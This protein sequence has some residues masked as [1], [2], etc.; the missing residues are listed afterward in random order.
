MEWRATPFPRASSQPRNRT[1]VS[2]ITGR[3]FIIWAT[4]EAPWVIARNMVKVK[5]VWES[6]TQ[7]SLQQRSCWEDHCEPT[8]SAATPLW[9][10]LVLAHAKSMMLPS[11]SQP[12]AKN[13]RCIQARLWV[14]LPSSDSSVFALGILTR[15]AKISQSCVTFNFR[16]FLLNPPSYL[17]HG[18][19]V[20][21]ACL[22][23]LSLISQ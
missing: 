4:R 16:I 10:T 17:L 18:L 9:P 15:L 1:Q 5:D 20:S 11:Y 8:A 14:R 21:S 12:R 13:A 2:H 3:F 19:K 22:F 6:L 7:I 23:S